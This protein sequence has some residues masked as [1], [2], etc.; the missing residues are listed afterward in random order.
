MARVRLT[1]AGMWSVAAVLATSV[2]A[3]AQSRSATYSLD[4]WMTVTSVS[5]YVLSP[6]GRF[7]YYTSDAGSSG[8]T[9][10]FRVSV[11]GGEPV[12]L[13]T[14]PEGVRPE[15]KANLT[16]SGDGAT[17]YYA[18]ARY[19]QGYNNIDRMPATGG[20]GTAL[21]FNDAVIETSPAPSPAGHPPP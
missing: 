15:P 18:S 1:T 17:L 4:D 12:Q 20:P 11:E 14:N 3:G 8:T 7:I 5:A 21:T 16:I 2:G 13:S 9:E 19:F 6:D 10:I